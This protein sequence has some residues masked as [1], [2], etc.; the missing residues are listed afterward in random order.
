MTHYLTPRE[1]YDVQ[2]RRISGTHAEKLEQIDAAIQELLDIKMLECASDRPGVQ[3]LA[4][5]RPRS[6]ALAMTLT[7]VAMLVLLI[8]LLG[9]RTSHAQT[10]SLPPASG[11]PLV[12]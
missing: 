2:A 4:V 8:L 10:T 11:V 9:V 7:I 1:E 12:Q 5:P 6:H 3:F